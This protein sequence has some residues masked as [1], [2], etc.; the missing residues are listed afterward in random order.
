MPKASAYPRKAE[1]R[2]AAIYSRVSDQSQ[3]EEDKTSLTE[4]TADMEAYCAERGLTVVG[5][6]S[7]VGH[8]WSKARP[9]F[10]RLLTDARAGRFDTIVCW[11]SD[12]LSRGMYPAAELMEVVEAYEIG[13]ESVKDT[14]DLKIFAIWAVFGKI[15]IDNFRERASMG[16]RGMAKQGRIPS[17]QVPYGYRRGERGV[18][19]IA[20]DEAEVVR[21]IFDLSANKGMGGKRIADQLTAEGIPTRKLGGGWHGATV[22]RILK[23]ETYLG[24]WC[25]GKQR[26][27]L[28]DAG[29][30][31]VDQPRDT[32]IPV[33]FPLLVSE[34]TWHRVQE[35]MAL[36]TNRAKRNTRVTY[37]LQHLMRCT[38]CETLLGG[39]ATR[40]R[41]LRR[42]DKVYRY[43]LDP[44]DRYYRCRGISKGIRDCRKHPFIRADR[45]EAL[46]WNEVEGVLQQ[47]EVIISGIE[48]L[49][50]VDEGQLK[51]QLGQ[52]ERGLGDVNAEG[53]RLLRLY[54]MG[55]IS[56]T[57]FEHQQAFIKE[58]ESNMRASLDG[59]RSQ[60]VMTMEAWNTTA[61][62]WQWAEAVREGLE[63]LSL[64][65]RREVLQ[66][67]LE[68][69]TIDGE[70]Q[71]CIVFSIP[72]QTRGRL[73][74]VAG[75]SVPL[76]MPP[77]VASPD[78]R[79]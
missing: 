44:P 21:R 56:E 65:E 5:R 58:R 51:K 27:R 62:V 14:L 34:D 2:R 8:G 61:G 42:G 50:T 17:N 12:R 15:E 24:T 29:R 20:E 1:G 33:P 30:L 63:A 55:R 72:I 67:L 23:N 77:E 18:P 45:L 57:E 38:G 73:E 28:T 10:Q 79:R 31:V 70:D 46:I 53:Q 26:H 43:D 37:L 41:T 52:A 40:R 74:D 75:Q 49:R 32:W 69:V 68:C 78:L 59:Y 6:Y 66:L 71:V 16:R 25:Y 35:G 13:L 47:P 48:S 3:A 39:K 76:V 9:E 11:K 22:S 7:E 60:L 4:Q 64:E 19:E 36:R 54:V